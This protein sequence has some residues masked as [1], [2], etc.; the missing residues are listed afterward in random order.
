VVP[1]SQ[2]GCNKKTSRPKYVHLFFLK[3]PNF[4]TLQ[5]AK[6]KKKQLS[7]VIDHVFSLLNLK[8][9]IKAKLL[10]CDLGILYELKKILHQF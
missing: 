10:V 2:V 6:E 3:T 4:F 5:G 8:L 1:N 9:G 7:S